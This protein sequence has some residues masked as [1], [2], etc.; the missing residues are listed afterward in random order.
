M[1]HAVWQTIQTRNL[2]R[3][4]DCVLVGV[5]GGAD[6]IALLHALHA[7]RDRL[8]ISLAVA[9]LHHGIRGAEADA[10][11]EFVQRTA[12]R[13]GYPCIVEHADVPARIRRTGESL[14]M[15]ARAERL[16]FFDRAGRAFG[17]D[18]IALAHT[19]DDAAETFLIRLL[20]G[21]GLMGLRGLAPE[22]RV[23]R[24][25]IV[26]PL[27]DISRAQVEAFLRTH[28]IPWRED[29]SNDD[30]SI[31][32]NRIRHQLLPLLEREYQPEIRRVLLRTAEAL[33]G[34]ADL[35]E[36][37]ICRAHE[38]AQKGE[39]LAV[40]RL[41]SLEPALRRH[42]LA[43][44]LRS[45]G[46][47][48]SRVDFRMIER[49]GHLVLCQRG[50]VDLAG[51]LVATY[52]AGRISILRA[53]RDPIPQPSAISIPGVTAWGNLILHAEEATGIL[54]PP[55]GPLGQPPAVASIRPPGP[56][57]SLELR[58]PWP[59]AR[60]SPVGLRGS[61]KL[62]DLFVNRKVPASE[63]TRVPLVACGDEV[64][65]VPGYRVA[66]RWAVPSDDAPSIHLHLG[67]AAEA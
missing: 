50:M 53:H 36:P 40:E 49:V 33:R 26:R 2:I 45:R 5:S 43:R 39:D 48:E 57:E 65:W 14:E 31:L 19:A 44:W 4:G 47:P 52:R 9:H 12:W 67:R 58:A 17:A 6:S 60:I 62:Q 55:P 27:I 7:F 61:V 59:G 1:L 37:M 56:G 23:G 3:R 29:L 11:A 8:A 18:A 51:G 35:V 66:S 30:L 28:R 15:A 22:S 20:R 16:A 13:L 32:R 46:V 64:V 38:R 10:D 25:R 21:S 42:V 54:R 41:A 34:D 63:R 24:L